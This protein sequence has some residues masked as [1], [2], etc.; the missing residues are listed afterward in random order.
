MAFDSS[1][2]P[3][4]YKQL[5]F[6]CRVCFG[7]GQFLYT[8]GILQIWTLHSR[9]RVT[10]IQSFPVKAQP[11]LWWNFYIF[12]CKF[13]EGQFLQCFWM[14]QKSSL[15]CALK[16]KQQLFV[17]HIFLS[18]AKDFHV[19]LT[20]LWQ[21]IIWFQLLMGPSRLTEHNNGRLCTIFFS[22]HKKACVGLLFLSCGELTHLV[23]VQSAK[24]EQG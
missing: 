18:T 23:S 9:Q 16:K 3:C 19:T 24:I 4:T 7:L 11:T 13:C 21:K 12:H 6:Q 8:W 14:L 2:P 10:F 1:A 17:G 20:V 5:Q 22:V 15:V